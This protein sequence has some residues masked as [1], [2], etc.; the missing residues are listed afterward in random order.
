MGTSP[1]MPSIEAHVDALNACNQRGGRMLSLIDLLKDESVSLPMAGYLAAAMRGGASLLVG[2]NPGG[3]GKTTVMC[4][5]LN[6]LPDDV[7]LQAVETSEVLSR[8]TQEAPGAVCYVAHEISPATYY[9]AYIWGRDAKRFLRLAAD[10][11]I[12]AAN[13]HA[14]T[15]DETR[16]QLCDQNGVDPAHLAAV[17]LKVYLGTAGH[18][19]SMQRWIDRVYEN[20]GETDQLLWEA[21]QPGDF[22]Q[23]AD[24]A[25]VSPEAVMRY[26]DFLA[27]LQQRRVRRI[28]EVRRALVGER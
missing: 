28:A 9:Y 6:F 1:D 24:S 25:Y 22:V 19:F 27:D 5:L 2:A 13:L 18:R 23:H 12:I 17:T 16:V 14:D 7:A 8:A 11:H 21:Q 20:D 3:A 15:L 10:G 4:A 26:R